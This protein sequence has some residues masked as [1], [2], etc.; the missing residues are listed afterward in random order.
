MST[1]RLWRASSTPSLPCPVWIVFLTL[2]IV[3][4]QAPIIQPQI[5]S[6]QV[7]NATVVQTNGSATVLIKSRQDATHTGRFSVT[8]NLQCNSATGYPTGALTISGISMTDSTV[9]GV[10]TATTF[11]QLT[12]TGNAEPTAYLN[13]RCNTQPSTGG[14]A[15]PGCRYWI[16]FADNS[17]SQPGTPP[18]PDVISFLVFDKSGKRVAYGTGPV[19]V[20]HVA[21]GGQL[22]GQ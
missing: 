13:G 8:V 3:H 21:V 16:L 19:A 20:G 17:H 7:C 15:V 5:P 14:P 9:Q 18:T 4:A 22:P 10:I 1:L 2:P 11:E 12:S 6:L